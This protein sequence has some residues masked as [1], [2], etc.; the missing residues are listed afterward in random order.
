MKKLKKL[1]KLHMVMLL[2][3]TAVLGVLGLQGIRAKYTTS[4]SVRGNVTFSAELAESLNLYEHKAER[5]PDG[6]YKLSKTDLVG[7]V[8][9]PNTGELTEDKGNEY[10]V[11]PGVDIPKDPQIKITGKSALDSYL[12]VEIEDSLAQS[13]ES[14]S[15]GKTIQYELTDE[16]V[17]LDDVIGP[18][19]TASKP[20]SVYVYKGTGNTPM[21]LDETF[22][23]VDN[24]VTPSK[25]TTK[26]IK[27]LKDDT[28]TV[29]E[30]YSS[31]DFVLNIYAHL[32]QIPQDVEETPDAKA[33]F[34]AQLPQ[35]S[36]SVLMRA[37][38]MKSTLAQDAAKTEP[39]SGGA[40]VSVAA[41]DSASTDPEYVTITIK[42]VDAETGESVFDDYVATLHYGTEFSMEVDSPIRIGYEPYLNDE[43]QNKVVIEKKEYK[44][45]VVYEVEY[46]PAL[47]SYVVRHYIQNVSDDSYVE[48]KM[49]PGQLLT[50]SQPTTAELSLKEL[51]DGGFESLYHEPDTVAADGSTE[52]RVYYDR[53]YFLY[54]FDCNGGYGVD[55]IYARY[56]TPIAVPTPVKPGYEFK[57][58]QKQDENGT[59]VDTTVDG[60]VGLADVSY[61]AK[62]EPIPDGT[63]YTVIYWLESPEPDKEGQPKQY[64]YWGSETV[65]N[66]TA[67]TKVDGSHRAAQLALPDYQYATF[68][69]EKTDK[70]IEVKGDGSTV[71]NVYYARKSYTLKFYYAK[72]KV[73]TEQ[74]YVAG[75]TTWPFAWYDNEMNKRL[76]A[77]GYWGQVNELP[78]FNDNGKAKGYNVPTEDEIYY[79]DNANY[80]YYSF[81]FTAK[82]GADLSDLWPVD[83]FSAAELSVEGD[84]GTHAYFSAWNVEKNT[85]YDTQNDNKT[86]KGRYNKLDNVLLR[87]DGDYDTIH[88]LAFW[89]NG[90]KK[91][92][93]NKPH[94]WIYENYI[95]IL[96]GENVEQTYNKVDYKLHSTYIV[97]DNNTKDNPSEQTA[98]AIEGFTHDKNDETKRVAT[99]NK[100]IDNTYNIYSYTMKFFYSRNV[101][102]LQMKNYDE[103]IKTVDSVSFDKMLKEYKIESPDE[104]DSLEKGAYE[105][106]GWYTSPECADGTEVDWDTIKM[107]DNDLMLY[108]KW[109]PIQRTVKFYNHYQ[110]ME[111]NKP[112][113]TDKFGGTVSHGSYLS[114]DKVPSID[115]NAGE[116]SAEGIGNATN[117]TPI[118]W[119]YIDAVTGEKKRFEPGT[120][121]VTSDLDLF[122][123]WRSNQVVEYTVEYY[124]D[125]GDGTC[126]EIAKP[127]TGYSF[128]GLTRTFKAKIG[129][130]LYTDYQTKHYPMEASHSILM[131]ETGTN[132]FRF[133]YYQKDSVKYKINYID[134]LTKLPMEFTGDR[135]I[136]YEGTTSDAV[137]TKKFVYESGY[138]PDAFYKRLILSYPDEK[139]IINFYYTKDTEHAYYAVKH[140]IEV[141]DGVYEE[142][143]YIQG[144]GDIGDNV[145]AKALAIGGY[146]YDRE[147]TTK[148]NGT[149]C[150]VST[151]GVQGKITLNGLEMVIYYKRAASGYKVRYVE[152]GTDISE[153]KN[154]LQESETYTGRYG[155]PFKINPPQTITKK[156]GNSN[157]EITYILQGDSTYE[158]TMGILNKDDAGKPIYPEIIFYYTAKQVQISYEAV[159]KT[160][161]QNFGWVSIANERASTVSGLGGC[162]ATPDTGFQFVGWYSDEACTN[163]VSKDTYYK[164]KTLPNDNTTY[165]A[166]FEPILSELT[167]K[168]EGTNISDTD[169]FLFRVKGEKGGTANIDLTVSITGEGSVT[170]SNLPIGTYT[171]TELTDWSWRYTADNSMPVSASVTISEGPDST[172]T[173]TNSANSKAWLGGEAENSN[174]FAAYETPTT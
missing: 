84:F 60:T 167:I 121:K 123:E 29:G 155:E 48:Y 35:K 1:K 129:E 45:N 39:S 30:N 168:K 162:T 157:D 22:T 85:L 165:Y 79:H 171:V 149:D 172:V 164:P 138:M 137:I 96:E 20:T 156:I 154:D 173:F 21:I 11:M 144:V 83:I 158:S 57:G 44:E 174:F 159:C 56:E 97:Y 94:Q 160:V 134:Q 51:I 43:K 127:T 166:L 8:A 133:L 73:G 86:L 52:F 53:K 141:S 37:M 66:A 146:E 151:D 163:Q 90:A 113:N 61:K 170:I 32:L 55:P 120:M 126:T 99:E 132:T 13:D 147:T 74:Y 89:E 70:Q 72:Q 117:Y 3:L 130:E 153:E 145:T 63:K 6:S 17:K 68:D 14:D 67:D 64:E 112:L 148:K 69:D 50:G 152:Y 161:N 78:V 106:S 36:E 131:T 82:Y 16:W 169:T 59:W 76:D 40:E 33:I 118:G 122:M 111:A 100:Q 62:W 28:I 91:V 24:S 101:H 98:T 4:V 19:G 93:W 136:E 110:A 92:N 34:T 116:I 9:G 18:N 5:L 71:V 15:T 143:A 10:M 107:P 81:Q 65:E 102:K 142:Y 42:Y 46:R 109:T 108:A 12:Y 125:N 2:I 104:P 105:F 139:N 41:D 31:A 140:M 54:T 77:V 49:V 135:K 95:P 25:E 75:G 115:P 23:P 87:T 27:I 150:T 103:I 26:I 38:N 124:K 114:Q 7:T 80:K 128:A 58:W 88:F 47:V 119:F